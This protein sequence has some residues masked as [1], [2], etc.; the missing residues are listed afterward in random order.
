ME[1]REK[2]KVLVK[3]KLLKMPPVADELSIV[4]RSAIRIDAY[5][6]VAGKLKYGADLEYPDA[7]VGKVLR[8]PYPHA[9]IKRIEIEKARRLP[10]VSV[11]LTAEHVPGRNG[12]GAVIPDQ[13]VLC[14]DKVRYVGDGVAL[15]AAETEEIAVQALDLIEVEYEPLPAVFS[16]I[17]ALRPEAS[18]VHAKGNLLMT[19][20]IR[21]GDVEKGFEEADLI[22]E[23]TYSVPF[24]E[25]F[26]IEPDVTCAI[27]HPDGTITVKGPMQAPFTVRRNIAPVLG[28]P[29]NKVQVV[30]TP[31]GGGFGGKEDSSIDI[32]ARAALLAWHTKK[33]VRMEYDREEITLST[34]K[35][36]P[37]VIQCK[38]GVKKDGTLLAFEGRIY[39]EQGAYASLGPVI[40]PAGGT[41]VHAV[42]MLP[43]PY[44]IPNI[45]V[46]GYLVYTNHPYGGAMRGFGAPQV[47]FVHESLIDEL[48]EGLGMDP[49]DLRMKN[50]F[51]LGSETATGQILDQSVGLKDTMEKAKEAFNWKEKWRPA[52]DL[53]ELEKEE[54]RKGVG[55]ALGWYRTSIGTSSDG[56]GANLHL[57]ED[58]S[59]LL[60]QGIT[61]M[62]Q[63]A[64]TVLSQIAAEALGVAI[65]DVRVI[66]PD[67]DVVPEAGPTV[68]SR[69]TT[70]M[71]NAILMAAEMIKKP[72]LESASDLLGIPP[73]RL[74]AKN[75]FIYDREDPTRCIELRDAAKRSMAMGRRM[76][77]QGWYTPPQPSLNLETGQGSPYFV[78]TY[79]TQMAEVEVDIKTGAVEVVKIVAAFDVGK[80]INPVL[81]EAQIEGGIMMGLGYALMEGLILK[82]GV[83][84]N[85]NFQDCM[86]PTALDAPEITPIMIEHPT[87]HGPFGAKGIGEMPNIPTAPAITNA[88]ANAIGVRIY[89]LPAHRERVSMGIKGRLETRI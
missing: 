59:V 35:R 19:A 23:R 27:P 25:H 49:Y 14:G 73:N 2:K 30:Q 46:D 1:K 54:K 89:D 45:N 33:A 79:C 57:L 85:L 12:F 40:P 87:I 88:I 41:H 48:A 9:L 75:R 10:G 50:S 53:E 43:G 68:G 3:E 26:Y 20:R 4:G 24:L 63:G 16:P 36:H 44:V 62:G 37:M 47:N 74:I 52:P 83:I 17:E 80:A 56:C 58:G 18:K 31:L 72:L 76:L 28:I 64:Y 84:Q 11:V 51:Q 55:M 69:S 71:G 22:L 86:I 70:L 82:E 77:G 6:K 5:D 38:I 81:V 8:S 60:Y 66:T 13:P 65:E 78:Y 32:G 29:I 7:L 39:N 21:K 42:V 34:A 61:E 67:T 15:V